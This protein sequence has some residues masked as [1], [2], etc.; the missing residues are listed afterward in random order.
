MLWKNSSSEKVAAMAGTAFGKG[1]PSK[2]L[3]LQKK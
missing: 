1:S 3:A 2:Q